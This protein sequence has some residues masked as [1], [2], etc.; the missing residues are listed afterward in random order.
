[1]KIA[2]SDALVKAPNDVKFSIEA[3]ENAVRGE[4]IVANLQMKNTSSEKLSVDV[5][6]TSQIVRYTGVALMKLKRRKTT[7]ELEAGK[8]E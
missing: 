5:S 6:L 7:M 4:N 1:M 2:R 3:P 8:G